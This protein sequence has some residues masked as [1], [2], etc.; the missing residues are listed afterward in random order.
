MKR[1]GKGSAKVLRYSQDK[2]VRTVLSVSASST[3]S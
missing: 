2:Y 1:V 3:R